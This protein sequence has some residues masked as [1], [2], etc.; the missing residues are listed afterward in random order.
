MTITPAFRQPRYWHSRLRDTALNRSENHTS[1]YGSHFDSLASLNEH[2][3]RNGIRARLTVPSGTRANP[4]VATLVRR[5][6]NQ[7]QCLAEG[8]SKDAL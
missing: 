2:S 3:G 6:S 1:I 4:D 8:I 7:I 5:R